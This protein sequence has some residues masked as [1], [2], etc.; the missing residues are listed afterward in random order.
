ME[1]YFELV[2]ETLTGTAIAGTRPRTFCVRERKWAG[3]TCGR[4]TT[5][6]MARARLLGIGWERSA[7]SRIGVGGTRRRCAATSRRSRRTTTPREYEELG[8]V[9]RET[10]RVMLG[11]RLDEPLELAVSRARRHEGL[12][13]LQRLGLAER[14]ETRSPHSARP[15]PRDGVTAALLA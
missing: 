3:A 10:E 12:A 1:S 14:G 2:V 15:L 8:P 5:S 11:L 6:A 7:Q 13:R 9:T 4:G